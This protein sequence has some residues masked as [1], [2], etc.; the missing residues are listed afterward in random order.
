MLIKMMNKVHGRVQHRGL[1]FRYLSGVSG[2]TA[3]WRIAWW[4][5]NLES[6][7]REIVS[8]TKDNKGLTKKE[9]QEQ[10]FPCACESRI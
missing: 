8:C 1:Q 5:L 3:A 9:K 4:D 2:A 6:I 7:W 10:F